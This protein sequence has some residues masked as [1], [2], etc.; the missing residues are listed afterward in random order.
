MPALASHRRGDGVK[1]LRVGAAGHEK[2]AMIDQAGE[3][4]DLS[5]IMP[6]LAGAALGPA[7]LQALR[8]LDSTQLPLLRGSPRIGPC[9]G[10]VGKIVCV[11]LN[12]RDHAAE[13]GMPIPSEP[14]LFMKPSSA[15]AGPN[16]DLEIPPGAKKIDW[17]VELGIVIGSFCKRCPIERALEHVAGYCIIND[18][19]ERAWQLERGGQW[20]KGKG[21]DGFAPVG[22]WL[23]TREEIPDPQA[24]DLWL[25]I[26]GQ[27]VQNSSTRQMIFP[28][29]HVVSY[30]SQFMSL[31]PGDLIA[32]GTP[33]GVG[34][35]MK[36]PRF[37]RPGQAMQLGIAGLGTQR[38]RA[39]AAGG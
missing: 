31:Q 37:L 13:A 1:L 10:A 29:D 11:G 9:V 14:V 5:A 39:V 21:A 38:Q 34:L 32:T 17:E 26:D 3:L 36:P 19:S 15:I 12:Y 28:V 27:R 6:D 25:E 2:P 30:I 18:V 35:G 24:L 4:R 23:V 8:A 7:Q 22:P 20:D 16:D 33:P